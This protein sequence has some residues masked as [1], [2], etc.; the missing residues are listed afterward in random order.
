MDSETVAAPSA[1]IIA[2]RAGAIAIDVTGMT[3]ASCVRRVERALGRVPGVGR[4]AVSLASERAQVSIDHPVDPAALVRAVADA[5][6]GTA[7]D[8]V[9]LA[10]GGMTCAS[11]V[12]RVGRA[13][14]RVPGVLAAD[15]NL[16]TERAHVTTIRGA[17]PAEVLIAAIE[18]A[19]YRATPAAA[20]GGGR[21]RP[22]VG[23][24]AVRPA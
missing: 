6:Y 7:T 10:I 12:G 23:R 3:C 9:E 5:G 17:A 20:G 15:V 2:E 22:D 18:R 14:G 1:E 4:V 21:A 16:V 24:V 11:C 19:G 8:A 13:L